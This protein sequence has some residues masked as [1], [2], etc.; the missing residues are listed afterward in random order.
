MDIIESLLQ[1]PRNEGKSLF[2]IIEEYVR[3]EEIEF[4]NAQARG[5]ANIDYMPKLDVGIQ[6]AKLGPSSL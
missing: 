5:I 4:S 3:V 2:D 1:H 6:S